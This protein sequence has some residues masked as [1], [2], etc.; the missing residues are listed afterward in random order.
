MQNFVQ[1][2]R[3]IGRTVSAA[4]HAALAVLGRGISAH[5]WPDYFPNVWHAGK[6]VD[7]HGDLHLR[8]CA[9]STDAC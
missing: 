8:T 3:Y 1:T 7:G 9:S 2:A 5:P 6:I 4:T